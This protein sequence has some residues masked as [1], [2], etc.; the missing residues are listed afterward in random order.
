MSGRKWRNNTE[1]SNQ[2]LNLKNKKLVNL[3]AN[4]NA[5]WKKKFKHLKTQI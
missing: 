2:L 5:N 1:K 4:E 3:Y